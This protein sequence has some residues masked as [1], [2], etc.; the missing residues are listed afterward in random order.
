MKTPMTDGATF[1][2]HIQGKA[3]PVVSTDLCRL[4]EMRLQAVT[5]AM[6]TAFDIIRRANWQAQPHEWR[7]AARYWQENT[8][9]QAEL[10]LQFPPG[11]L[12]S[13]PSGT[14][15]TLPEALNHIARLENA[16]QQA[17]RH[18]RDAEAFENQAVA[19]IVH[20]ENCLHEAQSTPRPF[21]A[22]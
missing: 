19:K 3:I 5:T 11:P 7:L 12:P 2:T 16:L 6:S 10:P 21:G 20:L 1:F 18:L 22:N 17:D 13:R 14:P 4:I 9:V 8:F 15:T